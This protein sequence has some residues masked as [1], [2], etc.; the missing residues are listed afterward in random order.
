MFFPTEFPT[1]NP[2]S[3]TD[4]E[5]QGNLLRGYEQKFAELVEQQDLTRLRSNAGFSKNIVK[6]QFF[7]T[8]DDDALD[9]M[10]RVMSR[11]IPYLEVRNHPTGQGG[12]VEPRRSVQSWK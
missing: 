12:S 6:G 2:I 4:A 5:V 10:K 11:V 3:Q 8:L 1:A 7:I 9:D